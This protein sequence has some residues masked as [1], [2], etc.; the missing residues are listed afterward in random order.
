LRFCL[1]SCDERVN[2]S[3]NVAALSLICRLLE[4]VVALDVG[5]LEV[6]DVGYGGGDV[7]QF[8]SGDVA[9]GDAGTEG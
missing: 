1:L 6:E 4:E 2:R 3:D 9:V 7:D 5:H 8:G